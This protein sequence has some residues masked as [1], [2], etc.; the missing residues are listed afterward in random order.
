[1]KMDYTRCSFHPKAGCGVHLRLRILFIIEV[2]SVKLTRFP[3]DRTFLAHFFGAL[4]RYGALSQRTFLSGA[5]FK[6]GAVFG[7]TFLIRRN[8]LPGA[9]FEYG[10]VFRRTF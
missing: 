10:A 3:H 4:F 1:M 2:T 5:L 6:Y 9:L 8:F 7:R